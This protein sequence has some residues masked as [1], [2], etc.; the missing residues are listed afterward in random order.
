MM[1]RAFLFLTVFYLVA[2]FTA[3]SQSVVVQMKAAKDGTSFRGLSVV[4]DRVAWVSGSNG[5][6]GNTTDGGN[7]WNFRQ[8][9]GFSELDFRSIYAFNESTAVIANAGAPAN[10]LITADGGAHWKTVYTNNDS[11]AFF[12]GIDFFDNEN[13]IIYGDPIQGRMLLL[14]TS[15]GGHSWTEFNTASR[16][17]LSEGEASFAAS[18]TNIR[19]VDRNTVIIAT[20]GKVSRLWVSRDRG[21]SWD[22]RQC[23]ILQGESTTGI[24]SFAKRKH[25]IVVVGGNYLQDTLRSKHVFYS[26]NFA[27]SWRSPS[28]PT[29]GYRESVEFV[30]AKRLMATGPTGMEMSNDGGK[31]WKPV[32]DEKGLHVLRKARNGDLIIVAGG[33]GKIGV[34]KMN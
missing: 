6:I 13:G 28:M 16:P 1:F 23:P 2:P 22:D 11:A 24:F 30:S 10:I 3:V 12:D 9:E 34:A 8:V 26:S 20:G 17:A 33:K 7:T 4:D 5:W 27:K 15:D 29:R 14:R 31:T 18:G 19:C 21:K 32:S 25:R